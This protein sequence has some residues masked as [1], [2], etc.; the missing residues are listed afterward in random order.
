MV[1]NPNVQDQESE[2]LHILIHYKGLLKGDRVIYFL[3]IVDP[4]HL[5][6]RT[7]LIL[8]KSNVTD[9]LLFH[10]FQSIM[11]SEEITLYSILMH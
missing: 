9:F 3:I 1:Q 4:H 8:A 6:Y 7:V 11:L 5:P 10:V 2:K